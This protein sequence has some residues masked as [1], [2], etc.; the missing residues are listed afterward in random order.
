MLAKAQ[1]LADLPNKALA[2]ANLGLA[3]YAL[4]TGAEFTGNVTVDGAFTVGGSS[5]FN[6]G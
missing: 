6:G 5:T 1:N 3:L 2:R 4:L